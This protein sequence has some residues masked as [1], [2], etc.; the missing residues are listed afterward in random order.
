VI[1]ILDSLLIV[2]FNLMKRAFVRHIP[3]PCEIV[4]GFHL[5]KYKIRLVQTDPLKEHVEV[6][7]ERNLWH[8]E[9]VYPAVLSMVYKNINKFSG[10]YWLRA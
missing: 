9:Q 8:S 10:D 2:F 7:L 5:K 6:S 4:H 1:E 3:L